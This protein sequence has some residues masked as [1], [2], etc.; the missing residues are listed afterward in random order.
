MKK[1]LF[2]L[3]ITVLCSCAV[4]KQQPVKRKYLT[5]ME[6]KSYYDLNSKECKAIRK[7]GKNGEIAIIYHAGRDAWMFDANVDYSK[8]KNDTKGTLSAK[9]EH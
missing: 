8:F 5:L 6:I 3:M 4:F 7:A 9:K 1:V 2:F